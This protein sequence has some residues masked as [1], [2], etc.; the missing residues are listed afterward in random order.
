M[1]VYSTWTGNRKTKYF[2]N[3]ESKITLYKRLKNA[4]ILKF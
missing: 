1:Y 4:L 2:F 3:P